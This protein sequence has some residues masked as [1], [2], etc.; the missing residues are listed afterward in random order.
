MS[1]LTAV[2]ASR[3]R[4][5]HQLGLIGAILYHRKRTPPATEPSRRFLPVGSRLYVPHPCGTPFGSAS[6]C[7]NPLPAVLCARALSRRLL[8]G[9][10]LPLASSYNGLMD[11][12]RY[13]YGDLHPISSCP[14]RAYTITSSRLQNR[15]A[16]F[17]RCEA[18]SRR[19]C[20]ASGR[21]CFTGTE[22]LEKRKGS[23]RASFLVPA[24]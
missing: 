20:T 15:Y 24:R 8:A 9:L 13:S 14:G 23:P 19:I 4:A 7:S 18:V 5:P 1:Y 16:V 11:S 6:G 17:G 12:F 22:E 21:A 2:T 10:P 3:V